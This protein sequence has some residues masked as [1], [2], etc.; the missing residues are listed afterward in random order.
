MPSG[1]TSSQGMQWYTFAL[2]S[3]RAPWYFWPSARPLSDVYLSGWSTRSAGASA[4]E[5]GLWAR[6]SVTAATK[7]TIARPSLVF[8]MGDTRGMCRASCQGA[9]SSW[10]SASRPETSGIPL[11]PNCPPKRQKVPTWRGADAR[12]ALED[13]PLIDRDRFPEPALALGH[14]NVLTRHGGGARPVLHREVEVLFRRKMA[15]VR[16][17]R[18]P[19]LTGCAAAG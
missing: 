13:L 3:R 4:A 11:T 10:I 14:G 19:L 2:R 8:V 15:R 16:S 9:L 7:P 12:L 17:P 6:A 1:F 18:L 5:A